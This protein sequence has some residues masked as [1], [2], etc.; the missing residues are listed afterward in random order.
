MELESRIAEMRHKYKLTQAEV[1]RRSGISISQLSLFETNKST[2]SL[3][4]LWRI[5]RAIGCRVDSLYRIVK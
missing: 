3:H 4:N 2:P 1:S 5:S